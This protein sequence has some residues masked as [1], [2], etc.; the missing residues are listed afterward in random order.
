MAA[1]LFVRADRRFKRNERV[2]AGEKNPAGE[3]AHSGIWK[4]GPDA[5]YSVARAALNV[6]LGRSAA[7]AFWSSGR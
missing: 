4:R 7:E 5:G 6:A 3:E 2:G 1:V